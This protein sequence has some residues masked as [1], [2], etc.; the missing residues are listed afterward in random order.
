VKH[1]KVIPV[2]FN[3]E[4]MMMMMIAAAAATVTTIIIY[5]YVHSLKQ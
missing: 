4:I 5:I 3:T 2:K 1:F